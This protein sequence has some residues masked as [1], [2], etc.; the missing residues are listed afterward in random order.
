MLLTYGY[1]QRAFGASR[2]VVGQSLV[3][4]GSSYGVP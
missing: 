4:D 3:I 2:D 1:W